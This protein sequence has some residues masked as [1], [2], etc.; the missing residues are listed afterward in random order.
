MLCVCNIDYRNTLTTKTGLQQIVGGTSVARRFLDVVGT[1]LNCSNPY[2]S[3]PTQSDRGELMPNIEFVIWCGHLSLSIN[4]RSASS[5]RID[6][7][8]VIIGRGALHEAKR[9]SECART[10][11][12]MEVQHKVWMLGMCLLAGGQKI[13][14]MSRL[15][16]NQFNTFRR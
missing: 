4:P 16:L 14:N 8:F 1:R 5:T 2:A 3:M 9:T 6:M 11:N 7:V 15:A 12:A 13:H 10:V